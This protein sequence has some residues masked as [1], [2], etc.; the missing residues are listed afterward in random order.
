MRFIISALVGDVF[1]GARRVAATCRST[2]RTRSACPIAIKSDP[3]RPTAIVVTVFAMHEDFPSRCTRP[4]SPPRS[5]M[6]CFDARRVERALHQHQRS[7]NFGS[8]P[9]SAGRAGCTARRRPRRDG[10]ASR[11]RRRRSRSSSA[12][13]CATRR[14][15][16]GIEARAQLRVHDRAGHRQRPP[17]RHWPAHIAFPAAVPA[18]TPA[19]AVVGEVGKQPAPKADD[20]HRRGGKHEIAGFLGHGCY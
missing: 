2:R 20:Q 17:R 1:R 7:G 18:G 11:D 3:T 10:P 16:V 9:A 5:R 6:N 13:P 8:S 19:T 12:G 14:S 15:M 4:S